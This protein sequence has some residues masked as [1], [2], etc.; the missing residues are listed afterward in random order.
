MLGRL[1]LSASCAGSVRRAGG[2]APLGGSPFGRHSGCRYAPFFSAGAVCCGSMSAGVSPC[3]QPA[4]VCP[5]LPCAECPSIVR[6]CLSRARREV[7]R[8]RARGFAPAPLAGAPL[9]SPCT[10]PR[11][12]VGTDF[13]GGSHWRPP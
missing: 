4:K 3:Q 1:A 5:L 13:L 10:P 9:G 6:H 12:N 7:F 8:C 2:H 11:P